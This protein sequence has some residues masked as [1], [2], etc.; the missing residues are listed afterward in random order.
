M[1]P[2]IKDLFY[3]LKKNGDG[4]SEEIR[5]TNTFSHSFIGKSGSKRVKVTVT[6]GDPGY[7][8]TSKMLGEAA[9]CVLNDPLPEKYGLITPVVAMGDYLLERLQTNAD[10]IF[11]VD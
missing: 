2:P 1:I 7:G 3:L 10:M 4:P 11:T 5:N 8:A 9:I 6:G